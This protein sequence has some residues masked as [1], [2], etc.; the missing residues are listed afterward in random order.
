MNVACHWHAL[1]AVKDTAYLTSCTVDILLHQLQTIWQIDSQHCMHLGCS[2]PVV[3]ISLH[4]SR[5]TE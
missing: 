1:Y 4:E 3:V 5:L 2:L